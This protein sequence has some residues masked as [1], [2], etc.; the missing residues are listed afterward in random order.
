MYDMI[1][2]GAQYFTY[3]LV[4]FIT[5]ISYPLA[6]LQDFI[7]P[8]VVAAFIG[9]IGIILKLSFDFYWRRKD[10][11]ALKKRTKELE[12]ENKTLKSLIKGE[13]S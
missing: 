13:P 12:I 1:Q 9:L 3:E 7:S 4:A 6:S 11:A 5:I 2:K 8:S 10:F